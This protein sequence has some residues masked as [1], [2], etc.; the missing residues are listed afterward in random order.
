MV[1]HPFFLN[2]MTIVITLNIVL[3]VSASTFAGAS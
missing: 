3:M 1:N 2:F